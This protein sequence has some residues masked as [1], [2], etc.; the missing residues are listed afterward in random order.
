[1]YRQLASRS[2]VYFVRA[3]QDQVMTGESYDEVKAIGGLGYIEL[4][5]DHN[6]D[7]NARNPWLKKMVGCLGLEPRT[8]GLKGRYSNQLS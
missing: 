3:M 6:F 8:F 2:E 5:G 4:E 1:M 7:G